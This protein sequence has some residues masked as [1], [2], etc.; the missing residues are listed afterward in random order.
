MNVPETI[1]CVDCGQSA[2]LISY[3]PEEGWQIGD[4]VVYRCRGCNDR[5]DLIVDESDDPET[6]GSTS[7]DFRQWLK[8][9]E[10][11]A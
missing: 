11:K 5:W 10:P 6:G 9:R 8:D 1:T 3:P 2:H 4:S 7:F